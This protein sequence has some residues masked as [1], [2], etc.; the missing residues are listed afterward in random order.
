MVKNQSYA[1]AY[2]ELKKILEDLESGDADVDKL[3][4]KVKQASELLEYCQGRLKGAEIEV[5][6]VVK[7][8]ESQLENKGEAE[9]N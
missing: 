8:L 4:A 5:K 9:D 3:S 6:K 7:K 2:D 1:Q